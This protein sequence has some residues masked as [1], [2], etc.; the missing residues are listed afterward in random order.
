MSRPKISV[1]M[2]ALN[3]A[4]RIERAL[5]SVQWADEIV[6]VDGGSEDDTREIAQRFG[7]RVE[8]HPWPGHFGEQVQR[9]ID[10]TTGDFT[11][12][13]D[14]DEIVTPELAAAVREVTARPDAA[15]GYRMPRRNRFLGKW[16]R[17]AGWWPDRQLRLFR[18]RLVTVVGPVHESIRVDGRIEDL[19][20]PLDHDTHPTVGAALARIERYSD[21]IAVERARRKTIRP[22]HLFTHPAGAFLRRYVVQ[23][24]WREGVHGYLLASI[25]AVMKFAVYAKAWELQKRD[26]RS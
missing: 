1:C 18:P 15:D 22:V 26:P 2:I 3:E 20:A 6:V 14:A 17:H 16:I 12:R 9:S 24:G 23:S 19:E 11:L 21:L 25:H 13:L 5:E 7:A 8:L 10:A 4:E